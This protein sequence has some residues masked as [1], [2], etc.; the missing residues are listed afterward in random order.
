LLK[1]ADVDE[2]LVLREVA[3]DVD[4][5]HG[6]AEYDCGHAVVMGAGVDA[7]AAVRLKKLGYKFTDAEAHDDLKGRVS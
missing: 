4:G 6:K 5:K 2:E 7:G 3:Q 1:L